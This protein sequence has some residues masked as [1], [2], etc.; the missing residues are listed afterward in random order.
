MGNKVYG[1]VNKSTR[2]QVG[3][4]IEV[5]GTFICVLK[6]YVT[7]PVGLAGPAAVVEYFYSFDDGSGNLRSGV[8]KNSV[9]TFVEMFEDAG[10][11]ELR[12]S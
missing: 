2:I 5:P 11:I 9:E 6:I 8:E 12:R 1:K 7:V 4:K 3:D 10:A